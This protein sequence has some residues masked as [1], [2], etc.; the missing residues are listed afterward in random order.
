MTRSITKEEALNRINIVLYNAT[1]LVHN[2]NPLYKRNPSTKYIIQAGL[3]S[4]LYVSL[5]QTI[6]DLSLS[7]SEYRKRPKFFS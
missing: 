5:K 2:A 7:N 1:E 4:Q 6:L 3:H